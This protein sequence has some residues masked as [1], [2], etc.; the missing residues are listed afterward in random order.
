[1][2][3]SIP[4]EDIMVELGKRFDPAEHTEQYVIT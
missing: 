4:L 2:K 3:S 1:M